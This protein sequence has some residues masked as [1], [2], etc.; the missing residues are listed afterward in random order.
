MQAGESA[1]DSAEP[2]QEKS[3]KVTFDERFLRLAGK[4]GKEFV[5]SF[6]D[7]TDEYE[8]ISIND[9]GTVTAELSV[10]NV[11]AL[12]KEREK[13]I[14]QFV[15]EYAQQGNGFKVEVSDD[16]STLDFYANQEYAASDDFY[17]YLA[18]IEYQCAFHQLLEH[19][20]DSTW[21]VKM[22]LY[23]AATGKIVASGDE[24]GLQY[25]AASWAASE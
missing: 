24:E 6:K 10:D 12:K 20:A 15:D 2:A 17:F 22:N 18:R 8:A 9:D 4:D 5:S 21:H 7:A 16:F 11:A 23:N 25:D 3:E 14:S 13:L 1:T 19:P